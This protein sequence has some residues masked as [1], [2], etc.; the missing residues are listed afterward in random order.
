MR[1]PLAPALMAGAVLLLAAVAAR[2]QDA[3]GAIAFGQAAQGGAVAYG[4]AWDYPS[5]DE[6]QEGARNACLDGGGSDCTVLA[7]FQ[8]GCGALAVDQYGMAQG[9]G[10]RSLEQAEARAL[11]TCEAAGGVGCAVVGSQCVSP[12]GQPDTW[13]GSESVLA[14]PEEVS[15]PTGGTVDRDRPGADAPRD[16]ELTRE[17]RMRVQQG[18]AALGFDAGPADGMFGPRT[19]SAIGEWQQA[20]GLEATGYLSREEAEVLAAAGAESPRNVEGAPHPTPTLTLTTPQPAATPDDVQQTIV[21]DR[22]VMGIEAARGAG[23]WAK[24]LTFVEKLRELGGELP[25]AVGYHQG[26]AYQQLGRDEEAIQALNG[27]LTRYLQETGERGQHY[28]EVQKRLLALEDRVDAEGE[29]YERARTVGTAAAWGE[30]LKDYPQGRYAAEARRSQAQAQDDEAYE[31][32]RQA[33]TPASYGSYLREYPTGRHAAEARRFQAAAERREEA[34]R[35]RPGKR[36]RDCAECPE[37]VV[38]PAGSFTMGSPASEDGRDDDEG[39]QHRVRIR[40]PFAV[41]VYEV[42]FAEWDACVAGGACDGHRPDDESWGR[43][44]RPVINVSWDDAQRYVGWLSRKTGQE[45]R[46]LSEAEWEYVARAGTTTPFHFGSTISTDQANYNGDFTYGAGRK[47]IVR[48]RTVA[49]G[50]FAANEFGLH[51]VHGNVWEL[52]QDCWNTSYSGAPNDGSAWEKG[53]CGRRV[54]RGGSWLIGPG[55]LRSA[56]RSWDDSGF[57]FFN[58]GFRVARTRDS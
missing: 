37:L 14:L 16:E 24:V 15:A 8:N 19:R 23:D 52:V 58:L 48:G 49:V 42:T 39:P 31:R 38:V 22:Y 10:A 3:H 26:V 40:E 34:E 33:D 4:L 56:L 32:A 18:L 47:G 36:F 35:L 53:E 13:S 46:L 20:K 11:R 43:G 54:V 6:A 1:N 30:Y 2:A 21:R 57:R 25:L 50:S 41:G 17:E 29:R 12:G 9:K 7:E 45:Y 51:D 5:R 27:Y 44:R 28:Q 55:G